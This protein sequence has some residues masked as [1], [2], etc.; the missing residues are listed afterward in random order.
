MN[1]KTRGAIYFCGASVVV[2]LSD[3]FRVY[4]ENHTFELRDYSHFFSDLYGLSAAPGAEFVEET[5]RVG[6]DSAFADEEFVGDFAVAEALRDQLE[7]FQLAPRDA[8]I[9][10]SLLV[11]SERLRGCRHGNFLDDEDLLLFR[12]LQAEPDPEASE[13][14]GNEPAVD[15]DRVL[16][17][18]EAKLNQLEQRRSESRRTGRR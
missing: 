8:E 12:E 3:D 1:W 17:D 13:E 11:E 14:R 10:Q 7:D 4:A 16:D 9:L 6:F 18:E 15:L 5:A 2:I